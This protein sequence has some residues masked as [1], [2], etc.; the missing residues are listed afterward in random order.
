[1]SIENV[2]LVVH[3][4]SNK[5]YI[6]PI[7]TISFAYYKHLKFKSRLNYRYLNEE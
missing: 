6:R 3:T 5:K 4:Y 7:S 2:F 1:M